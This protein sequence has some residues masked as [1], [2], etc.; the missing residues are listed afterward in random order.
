MLKCKTWGSTDQ[1]MQVYHLKM[2][3]WGRGREGRSVWSPLPVPRPA[4]IAWAT[5]IA[6]L[7][8]VLGSCSQVQFIIS[9]VPLLG[10][11]VSLVFEK[12]IALYLFSRF[13]NFWVYKALGRSPVM[14]PSSVWFASSFWRCVTMPE[15]HF[16]WSQFTLLALG[17]PWIKGSP[18]V[19]GIHDTETEQVQN[20]EEALSFAKV[21][22]EW[23]CLNH[24]WGG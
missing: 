11:L 19:V 2:C 24:V 6:S 22:M 4:G 1:T 7:Q 12:D 10:S 9:R 3:G 15:A 14:L 8:L 20:W 5:Q 21:G 18:V 16:C 13:S 23:K 17:K